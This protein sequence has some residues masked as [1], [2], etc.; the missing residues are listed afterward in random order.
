MTKT[1]QHNIKNDNIKIPQENCENFDDGLT[2]VAP[3][4]EFKAIDK[5]PQQIKNE[6]EKRKKNR[7]LYP[8][9]IVIAFIGVSLLGGIVVGIIIEQMVITASAVQ[10]GESLEGT[11]FNLQIDLNETEL[12]NGFNQTMQQIIPLMNISKEVISN[13]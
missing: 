3:K 12:I 5:T 1:P 13:D 4:G 6:V 9:W 8:L 7:R 10:I 11:T 2:K